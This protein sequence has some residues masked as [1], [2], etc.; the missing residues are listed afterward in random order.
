MKN[1]ISIAIQTFLG[2]NKE[3]GLRKPDQENAHVLSL[4]KTIA[5]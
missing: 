1:T 2:Q 4:L 3:G 5:I